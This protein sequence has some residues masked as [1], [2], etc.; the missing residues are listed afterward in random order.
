MGSGMLPTLRTKLELRL[1]KLVQ[2]RLRDCRSLCRLKPVYGR[3]KDGVR[4]TIVTSMLDEPLPATDESTTS[5]LTDNENC[6]ML[7]GSD[8]V[9]L[10]DML[11][12]RDMLE[13]DESMLDE[14]LLEDEQGFSVAEESVCSDEMQADGEYQDEDLFADSILA[15]QTDALDSHLLSEEIT[16]VDDDQVFDDF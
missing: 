1:W 4:T 5:L 7:L 10:D 6:W 12:S 8:S 9:S 3:N 2:S 16:G 11:E 13:P 14:I 15:S